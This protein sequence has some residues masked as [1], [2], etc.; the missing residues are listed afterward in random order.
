MSFY[1]YIYIYIYKRKKNYYHFYLSGFYYYTL[2]RGI[3]DLREFQ[4]IAS[5]SNDSFLSSD[6]DTN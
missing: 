3:L 6:Q 2:F 4:P 5:A 1:I